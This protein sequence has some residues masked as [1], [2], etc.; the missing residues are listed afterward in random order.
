MI[1]SFY[2]LLTTVMNQMAASSRN[3]VALVLTIYY[4][5]L[6]IA[7]V[8]Y[9]SLISHK[10]WNFLSSPVLFFS[11]AYAEKDHLKLYIKIS[12]SLTQNTVSKK[13]LDATRKPRTSNNIGINGLSFAFGHLYIHGVTFCLRLYL[14]Y[15]VLSLS[16]VDA[17]LNFTLLKMRL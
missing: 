2:G 11:I 1:S 8:I 13:P 9:I 14:L 3:G 7:E 15:S 12:I 5:S 10:K 17:I 6:F 4:F 16:Q